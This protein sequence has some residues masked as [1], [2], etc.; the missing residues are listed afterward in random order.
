MAKI[1]NGAQRGRPGRWLV[2]FTDGGGVRRLITCQSKSEAEREFARVVPLA[3]Q[4][5][6]PSSHDHNVSLA[7]YAKDFMAQF[8]TTNKKRST[9]VY[10]LNLNKHILPA[11]GRLPLRQINRT[12][13]TSY[14]V[15]QTTAAKA[16]KRLQVAI[17]RAVFAH[18]VQHNVVVV[19]PC[20]G[21]TKEL[22]L[23]EQPKVRRQ[24]IGKQAYTAAQ[25]GTLLDAARSDERHYPLFM[26]LSR[27]G[28]R[29]SEALGA[30]WG[31]VQ[32][33]AGT[34]TIERAISKGH[35]EVPKS[36][37]G[38][39]IDMTQDLA[40]VLRALLVKRKEQKLAR[41]WDEVPAPVFCSTVGTPLEESKVRKA[42]GRIVK[43][44]KLPEFTLHGFRHSYAS[45]LI[46]SG[47]SPA[48]VQ[49]QLG[50]SSVALTVDLYGSHHAHE[51]AA[52]N[53][54]DTL[55]KT[56]HR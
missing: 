35:R 23:S 51:S 1:L 53:A 29:I 15:R 17:L 18:A 27:T 49:A 13:I 2:D 56:A 9:D 44:A 30:E 4:K 25:L 24:R 32:W 42:L 46:A 19:N 12:M 45:I 39:T 26:F 33:D 14:L 22:K 55:V 8:A 43:A 10:R 36:G 41:G 5:T 50:H 3:Q 31:D 40:R 52:V 16:T 37:V 38:R 28:C 7:D 34:I 11:L 47:A 21:I 20:E 54:L 48:Y 6:G